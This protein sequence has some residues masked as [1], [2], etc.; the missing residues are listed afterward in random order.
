MNLVIKFYS[1]AL[2]L[3]VEKRALNQ[4]GGMYT[5]ESGFIEIGAEV[6]A[7][8]FLAFLAGGAREYLGII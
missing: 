6:A 3:D 1:R 5:E 7:K 4:M 2:R 8:W